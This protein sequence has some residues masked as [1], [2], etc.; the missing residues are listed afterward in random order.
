MKKTIDSF[1]ISIQP[2]EFYQGN[3][4]I[5]L[6]ENGTGKTTLIKMLAGVL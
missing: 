3:I 1:K 2:G 4:T 6:G 5:M